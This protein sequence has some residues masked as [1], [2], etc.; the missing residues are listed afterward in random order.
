MSNTEKTEGSN[1]PPTERYTALSELPEGPTGRWQISYWK[2][3]HDICRE[4][5]SG[6]KIRKRT[7]EI[8]ADEDKYLEN[9]SK[10]L[11][12][13]INGTAPMG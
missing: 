5:C 6:K 4:Y 10:M 8:E 12:P 9:I 11:R 1:Q 7:A 2:Y 3:G 13:G